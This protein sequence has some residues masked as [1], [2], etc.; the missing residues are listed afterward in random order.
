MRISI[1]I[2]T[3]NEAE[4]ID[5][6]LRVLREKA[7]EEIHEIIV[8]DGGST[9]Q[10]RKIALAAGAEVI[11]CKKTGRAAQLNEGAEAATGDV[12]YFI[13]ADTL[14]PEK[15]DQFIKQA[16][17]NG[18]GA[19]C[20]RLRFSGNHPILKFYSWFTRFKTTFVRFGDQTLFVK[21]ELF[22]KAGGF[23]E[24][25]AVMEDQEIVRRLKKK[26]R[27][28]LMDKSV[29]TSSRK[30]NE[31]GVFKLQFI[32]ILIFGLYYT[33]VHQETLLHLYRSLLEREN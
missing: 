8:S 19:G 23:D 2:P 27:F 29:V 12:L 26:S 7:R 13:H 1:I 30:Y 15:F 24:S 11:E 5:G 10:T 28:V 22:R 16:L 33:G 9:D 20:F 17:L 14:P 6:L 18:A 25:L 4:R 3:L 32:F 31:H 21:S